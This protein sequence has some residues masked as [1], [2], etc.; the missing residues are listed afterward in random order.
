LSQGSAL[1][2][3]VARLGGDLYAGGS[4]ALVPGPL[5]SRADRSLSLFLSGSRVVWHSFAEDPARAVFDHLG[6]ERAA[7]ATPA[8]RHKAA[9]EH[10]E[11]ERKRAAEAMRFCAA[12]WAETQPAD[13]SLVACY[14]A[15]ARG[16]PGVIP[17]TLRFHPAA[18]LTYARTQRAP[19]MVGL[20]SGVDGRSVGLHVT[21]LKPDGS[22]KAWPDHRSRRMFGSVKGGSIRLADVGDGR[23]LAV[24]E[25]IE[26]SL[27]YAT[28]TG[29]PTWAALSTSGL[30]AFFAPGGLKRLIVAADNDQ[31]G[32]DA[33]RALGERA[34]ARCE[35]V[36]A[37][38]AAPDWNDQLRAPRT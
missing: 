26:S 38:S 32:L 12:V 15:E 37:P 25:G 33:A 18:P 8:Q 4:R 17:A 36:I 31:A 14:L 30:R 20:V 11:A 21:A 5:H 24:G 3:I 19:A 1:R 10:Q 35:V 7:P 9:R 27:S 22:D 13:G 6:I 2:D 29:V 16:L 28:L 34:S 23:E